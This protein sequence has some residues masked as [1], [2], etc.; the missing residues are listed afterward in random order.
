MGINLKY[1]DKLELHIL[2]FLIQLIITSVRLEL[3]EHGIIDHIGKNLTF[4]LLVIYIY[5]M[6]E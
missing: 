3:N 4:A 1:F 5:Y 6:N 2:G